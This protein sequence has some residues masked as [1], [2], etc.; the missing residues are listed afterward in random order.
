MPCRLP[1]ASST[2]TAT[3]RS[4]STSS[5][6]R[7]RACAGPTPSRSTSTAP[8]SSSTSASRTA[9]TS[10]ASSASLSLSRACLVAR[11]K[12][13]K[14]THDPLARSEFTQ[15]IKGLQGERLRQAFRHFDTNQDGYID[16]GEFKRII[17]ELA[18]HK[19]SDAVLDKLDS[20][21]EVVP[22]GKI[23]YSEC[24]AFYNVR[25]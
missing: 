2:R 10:S 25:P 16:K 19:L 14:L 8:G 15:L 7:S 22:G 20:V 3:A 13:I 9:A 11:P 17:Y 18:R 12:E 5:R 6:A 4:S 23:S 21:S 24:I 1:S